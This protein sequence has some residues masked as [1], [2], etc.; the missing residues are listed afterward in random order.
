M[1]QPSTKF[2][3]TLYAD[4]TLAGLSVLIPIPFL[5]SLTEKFFRRRITPAIAKY[6]KKSLPPATIAHLNHDKST[7]W[8]R[9]GGCLLLPFTLTIGLLVQLSRKILYF[10]TVK[11][12]VD[13]LNYYWQRAFLLNHMIAVGHLD[14]A[15]GV[16]SADAALETVLAANRTSPLIKLAQDIISSPRK[17]IRGV[18]NVRKG[19]G[20]AAIDETRQEISQSWSSFNNH[21]HDLRQQ[22]EAALALSREEI[23]INSPSDN[24]LSRE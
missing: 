1:D 14:Q 22:Y 9:I 21:F 18:R 2:D 5:D 16:D 13:A 7:I 23:V 17:I 19:K 6:H 12:A 3:W 20:D 8:Q 11:K 4:A 10:L 15:E 24:K